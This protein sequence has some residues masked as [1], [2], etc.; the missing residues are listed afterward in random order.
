MNIILHYCFMP[1]EIKA[2]SRENT[3]GSYVIFVNTSHSHETQMNAVLHELCHIQGNDFS[4]DEQA[5]LLEK[6]LHG[7]SW[8]ALDLSQFEFF[9]A[10]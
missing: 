8:D 10:S 6:M 7:Y 4:R 3:D 9:V 1:C 5:D 2:F